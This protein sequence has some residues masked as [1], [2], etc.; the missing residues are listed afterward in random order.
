M[1]EDTALVIGYS[2]IIL[3]LLSIG[4]YISV[5]GLM[6]GGVIFRWFKNLWKP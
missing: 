3:G 2:V 4:S 5:F 1:I 6:I